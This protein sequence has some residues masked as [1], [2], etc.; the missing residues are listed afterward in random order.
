M[1][2]NV[3]DWTSRCSL[4]DS[5]QPIIETDRK[6]AVKGLSSEAVF[7]NLEKGLKQCL[8]HSVVGQ[9]PTTYTYFNHQI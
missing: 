3:F 4:S 5:T 8:S 9:Q 2:V 6:C 7:L 1:S